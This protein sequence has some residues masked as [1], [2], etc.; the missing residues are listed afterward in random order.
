MAYSRAHLMC[1]ASR[2]GAQSSLC[3]MRATF[4]LASPSMLRPCAGSCWGCLAWVGHPPI[5]EACSLCLHRTHAQH[6]WEQCCPTRQCAG[7]NT[8]SCTYCHLALPVHA[9]SRV[10]LGKVLQRAVVQVCMQV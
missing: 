6:N 10:D 8:A 7:M 1:R 9:E 4:G 5:C 3:C 2:E